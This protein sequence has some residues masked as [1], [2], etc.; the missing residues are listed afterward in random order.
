MMLFKL[1]ARN[2]QLIILWPG[3]YLNGVLAYASP[4]HNHYRTW[5]ISDPTLTLHR[6]GNEF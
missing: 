3:D 2:N 1:I 5:Q 4:E 6:I